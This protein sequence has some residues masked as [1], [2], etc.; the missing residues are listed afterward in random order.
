MLSYDQKIQIA[1]SVKNAC[2]E[3]L[4]EAYEEAKMSGLCQEGAWEV[5]VDAVKSLS[6]EKVII[7]ISE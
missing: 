5:A 3:T 7:R 6:L 1:M 2:L 4:I